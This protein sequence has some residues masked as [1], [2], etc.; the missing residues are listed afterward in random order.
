VARIAGPDRVMFIL[1]LSLSLSL[2]RLRRVAL[3]ATTSSSM[4]AARFTAVSQ[5]FQ[6]VLSTG[7]AFK[8]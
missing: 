3:V 6:A 8:G 1:S 2:S 5:R 4:H 7:D